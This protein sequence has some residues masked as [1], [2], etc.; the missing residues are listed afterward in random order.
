MATDYDAPR[1]AETDEPEQDSLDELAVG[2]NEARAAVIDVDDSES[3]DSFELPGAELF[4]RRT[5]GAGR[6]EAGQ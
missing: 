6:P 2:R 1:R 5:V 4:R 3:A